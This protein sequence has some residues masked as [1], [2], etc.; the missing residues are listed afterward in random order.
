VVGPRN[1][2]FLVKAGD[3]DNP[4]YLYLR[5][6]E[7]NLRKPDSDISAERKNSPNVIVTSGRVL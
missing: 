7:P 6:V 1:S 5:H 4:E 3:N 2:T